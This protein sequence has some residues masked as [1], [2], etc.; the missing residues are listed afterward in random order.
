MSSAGASQANF[1]KISTLVG[2]ESTTLSAVI[3]D[4]NGQSC[5]VTYAD[6][7]ENGGSTFIFASALPSGGNYQAL[8]PSGACSN[9]TSDLYSVEFTAGASVNAVGYMRTKRGERT[10]DIF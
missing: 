6:I 1:V 4:A 7:P 5:S 8:I 9:L 10:I 2:A 3:S